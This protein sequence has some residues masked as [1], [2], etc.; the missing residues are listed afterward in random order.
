MRWP[1]V[2]FMLS[3]VLLGG[4]LVAFGWGVLALTAAAW[5]L[6]GMLV[7]AVKY[8]LWRAQVFSVRANRDRLEL[9]TVEA[10]DGAGFLLRLKQYGQVHL[11]ADEARLLR[12]RLDSALQLRE[13]VSESE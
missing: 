7:A 10:G 1:E 11:T 8:D 5:L 4:A 2:L 12:D 13:I 6:G 3:L 9:E